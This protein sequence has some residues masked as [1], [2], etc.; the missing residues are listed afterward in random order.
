MPIPT[1]FFL[2]FPTW[3]SHSH[4]V[5]IRCMIRGSI[6]RSIIYSGSLSRSS[7]YNS[8]TPYLCFP[9]LG[10]WYTY[11]RSCI[12]CGSYIFMIT[13]RVINIRF[14]SAAN[15]MCSL[16]SS[17]VGPLYITSSRLSYSRFGFS[18]FGCTSGIHIICWIVVAGILHENLGTI[19]SLP[20]FINPQA[21]FAMFL[22][23]YAQC[24]SYLFCTV[25]PF[26][27]ILYHYV[28]FDICTIVMFEKLFG[29]KSLGGFIGT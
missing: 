8:S 13:G 18:Y 15:E 26:P 24:S 28:E 25:F 23:R 7:P 1:L 12:R 21:A 19:F 4:F 3:G 10:G 11:N 27:S 14:F 16:V 2:G 5:G 29:V 6:R 17:G 9:F 20:M 22:L